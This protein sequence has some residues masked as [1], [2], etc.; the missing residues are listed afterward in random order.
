MRFR[1]RY[2]YR[3][4]A[5]THI[6]AHYF[7]EVRHLSLRIPASHR[8]DRYNLPP[9]PAIILVGSPSARSLTVIEG[10]DEWFSRSDSNLLVL[11]GGFGTGKTTSLQ[12]VYSTWGD[13]VEYIFFDQVITL[14][15]GMEEHAIDRL[16]IP[17]DSIVIVD[18]FDA[19]NSLA[20]FQVTPP[21]LRIVGNIA[22]NHR[23]ILSTRRTPE[24]LGDEL[25]S[26]LGSEIRLTNLGFH[27]PFVLQLV[28]WESDQL[29]E[30]GITNNDQAL[31]AVS[32][33]LEALPPDES[34][35]LRRPLLVIMLLSIGEQ[36]LSFNEQ[37]SVAQIYHQYC[38]LALSA[39]YDQR[40]SRILGSLK[41]EILSELAYDIFS[42]TESNQ[43]HG[44]SALAVSVGR[45][46]ERVLEVVMQDPSLRSTP[47]LTKYGWTEDFLTTN[48]LFGEISLSTLS[49]FADK[50]FGFIHQSFYE[51]FVSLA[52]IRRIVGGHALGLE[53]EHLSL[54]TID[55]L[56]LAF[57]KELGGAELRKAIK[58]LV[59]RPRL[60]IADRLVLLYLLED[61]T[62]F[63]DILLNSPLE[64]LDTL[65]AAQKTANSFFLSKMMRYQLVIAGRYS[66]EEYVI[67]VKSHEDEQGLRAEQRLHSAETAVTAQLIQR[68]KN[69]ALSRARFI[70]IYR[71]GQLGDEE[72]IPSL[73]MVAALDERLRGIAQEAIERI[74][75]RSLR[76]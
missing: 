13:N 40:R 49:E 20:G 41:R 48:N 11:M 35:Y 71:L 31:T 76:T 27:N 25:L 23:I 73:E 34:A 66:A 26:Q 61:E 60:S 47:E 6:K 44:T 12:R 55:S 32:K 1:D 70:T 33:Y 21:D 10:L 16:R 4:Q 65:D 38:H 3:E 67:E 42:G 52:I 17:N 36:L 2:F 39:D 74:K 45:V 46:S 57:V 75:H 30:H 7:R 50:Q 5:L 29:R 68:L 37:P 14:N 18:N 62:D 63:A 51:Y 59:S 19:V 9:I 58:L 54:A 15:E 28:P 24:I 43:L 22:R 72:A 8:T 53:L 56:A 64:Y 69:P